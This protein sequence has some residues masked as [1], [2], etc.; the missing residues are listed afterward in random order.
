VNLE[1]FLDKAY[2]LG[3][4]FWISIL[5]LVWIAYFF[6]CR[7]WDY[8]I[9]L[10][11]YIRNGKY[12]PYLPMFWKGKK[13]KLIRIASVLLFWL[14]NLSF[15]SALYCLYRHPILLLIGLGLAIFVEVKI[16]S[17]ASGKITRLQRDR[18]FQIYTNLANQA[19]AKGDEISDSQLLAKT[20]WQQQN[21]LRLADKQGRLLPFLFGEA[22]L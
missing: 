8:P 6:L 11:K 2:G 3:S 20:Q 18:Y 15:A 9:V 13:R 5:V 17:Y 14:G 22:K 21:D 7:F 4:F 1:F 12:W 16:H 10:E 19:L